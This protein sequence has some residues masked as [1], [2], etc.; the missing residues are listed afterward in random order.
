M[1]HCEALL[2]EEGASYVIIRIRLLLVIWALCIL[3]SAQTQ[4]PQT[5]VHEP[6]APLPS[7]TGNA[8]P[9]VPP[10]FAH[11]LETSDLEAFFDGIIPLQLERSDVAGATV[12]VMKDGQVLLEK[13][14]GYS[15]VTKKKAVDPE[16]TIF[17]LASISKLFTWIAVM[18]LAEQ[19]KLNIDADVNQYLD[20]QIAPAFGKPITLRNLMTHTGGF[21]EVLRDLIVVSPAR[22]P[23]LREFLVENQPR[24]MYPP[25]EI[26][27]YSNYGVGLAGYIVQRVSGQ[28]YEV[29]VDEHILQ[30]LGMK[31]SSFHQPLPEPLTPLVSNGYDDSTEKPPVGFEIIDPAPAGALS[32]TAPDMGRLARAL[33]NGG[34]LDGQRILKP[35]TLSE[36]WTR[37]FAAS[38][39]LPAM[40]MGFYQQWYNGLHFVG[41]D[42]DLIAFHSMFYVE[43]QEKLVIFL[44]YNSAGSA[45][46]SRDELLRGFADRYYPS[47]AEPAFQKPSAAELKAMAGTYESTRRSDSTKMKVGDLFDYLHATADTKEGVLKLDDFKDLQGHVQKWKPLG[48]G[49]WQEVA[50]Q[51]LLFGIQDRRGRVVRLAFTFPGIQLQRV[52]WY[53][54]DKV[55][56]SLL[57]TS[58]AVALLV[59]LAT[60]IRLGRRVLFARR[61]DLQPQ[62]GTR[63]LTLAPRLAAFAWILVIVYVVVL[64]V[65]MTRSPIPPTSAT[66]K[67]FVI[68][69][70]LTGVAI[71]FSIFALIS[72]IRI[73]G[74]GDLRRISQ[75]KF[76]LVALACIFL[77]WFS[78]HWNLI[79]PAHR[80]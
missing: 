17:R 63:W 67:Y 8:L 22:T 15:D 73:W 75:L 7:T 72:G 79:G 6:T 59:V 47:A 70:L 71:F 25:G 49:L 9:T 62:P 57:C 61:T 39:K 40:D 18:Q 24:R 42:G 19:G 35:E 50:G 1:R 34:E 27:A 53:E 80:F 36:M 32:T 52:P 23:N 20:F 43:P 44:S 51:D 21:E 76:S 11:P 69:N 55:I 54:N 12:L 37:Q 5:T 30:P 58:A 74:R 46:K 10:A 68:C 77:T 28:P 78:I 14:Y 45:N 64:F 26:S 13:G 16:T 31:N 48:G 33:L 65:V 29:F 38:D 60:L 2:F 3:S 41:H 56:L 66:D 4:A